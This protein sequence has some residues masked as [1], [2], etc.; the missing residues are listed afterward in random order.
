MEN[1]ISSV[2]NMLVDILCDY[3]EQGKGKVT[4]KLEEY[5]IEEK[6]KEILENN[7][8]KFATIKKLKDPDAPKKPLSPYLAFYKQQVQAIKKKYGLSSAPEMSKKAG[9]LWKGLSSK[10]KAKYEKLASQDKERYENEKKEYTRP[11]E[12][13]LKQKLVQA[14]EEKKLKDPN[15][16]KKPK[17]AYIFF[18]MKNRQLIKDETGF[19]TISEISKELGSRWKQMEADEKKEYVDM[20]IQ[21]KDRYLEEMEEYKRPPIEELRKM[22][23]EKPKRKTPSKTRSKTRSKT[24]SKTPSKKSSSVKKPR[25]AYIFY[26][27]E[28]RKIVKDEDPEKTTAEI[29]KELGRMWKSLGDEEKERYIDMANEDKKRYKKEIGEKEEQEQE[30]EEKEEQEEKKTEKKKLILYNEEEFGDYSE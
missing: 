22:S 20:E 28:N 25:N 6:I 27:Q 12:E 24:P 14:K 19:T 13:E 1:I 10:E 9:E 30:Q 4:S 18:S 3:T 11:S 17:S 15:A 16:P 2:K 5:G 7:I 29:S 23:K 26:C 21:D 8:S